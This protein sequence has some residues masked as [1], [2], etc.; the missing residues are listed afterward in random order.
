[1]TRG[2]AELE[3]KGGA[4]RDAPKGEDR[5]QRSGIAARITAGREEVRLARGERQT[6]AKQVLHG[7]YRCRF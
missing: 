5:C 6:Q 7:P 1:M 3:R 4:L 2:A